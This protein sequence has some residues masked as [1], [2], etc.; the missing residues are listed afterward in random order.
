[1]ARKWDKSSRRLK[2]EQDYAKYPEWHFMPFWIYRLLA[3]GWWQYLIAVPFAM[4]TC[5]KLF[6]APIFGCAV[7]FSLIVFFSRLK[8]PRT[9]WVVLVLY[10]FALAGV[11]ILVTSSPHERDHLLH[12]FNSDNPDY[13]PPDG[14]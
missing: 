1:M 2:E 3:K 9:P 6:E 8:V 13:E 5:A 10:G 14:Q 4:V 11:C 7:A 12:S